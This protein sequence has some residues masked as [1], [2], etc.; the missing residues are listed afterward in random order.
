MLTRS[1]AEVTVTLPSDREIVLSRRFDRPR[2]LLFE[3][4]TN[5][6]H[7]RRW[8]A[9]EDSALVGCEVDLRVG[10][11]WR[12]TV[13]Q[14][15]GGEYSLSGV[16]REIVPNGRLVYTEC[17]ENPAIGSPEWLTTITFEEVDGGTLL[18]HA[19]LHRSREVRD[20]HLNAGMHM[21]TNQ[22]WNRLDEITAQM[23]KVSA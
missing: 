14:A 17:Y 15:D 3:A 6:G 23:A 5:P 1:N 12:F 21:G 13:R 22:T 9:C 2:H 7:L 20:G 8:W 11:P 16:Y 10:G 18:T 19:I 4:W